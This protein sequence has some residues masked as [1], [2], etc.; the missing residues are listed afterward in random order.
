MLRLF[1]PA[2]INLFF[3]VLSKRK[4]GFHEIFSLFQTLDFGD[5]LTLE[6][7]SCQP[8]IPVR[9]SD[10]YSSLSPVKFLS[11]QFTISLDK[12]FLTVED[13]QQILEYPEKNLILKAARLFREKLKAK[14]KKLANFI[15]KIHLEK[16][17]PVGS[18]LGGGSS[19]AA[20]MLFGLNRLLHKPFSEKELLVIA[21]QLGSD[22]PFFFSSGTALCR[23]RGEIFQNVQMENNHNKLF[24]AFPPCSCLTKEVFLHFDQMPNSCF[25]QKPKAVFSTDV[26]RRLSYKQPDPLIAW[27]SLFFNDLEKAALHKN[28]ELKKFKQKLLRSG[29]QKVSMTG[30]GSCFVCLGKPIRQTNLKLCLVEMLPKKSGSWYPFYLCKKNR[31]LSRAQQASSVLL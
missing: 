30:S 1:S 28:P 6:I 4:D 12:N 31:S 2:K 17:I 10:K 22:V 19:N 13:A 29:F 23:G 20:T 5:I 16:K 15:V 3:Q 8:K 14:N 9:Q 18:G 27:E 24:L 25:K 11:D 21:E 26:N 7:L